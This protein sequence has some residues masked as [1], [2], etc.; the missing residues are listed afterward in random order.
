MMPETDEED[1]VPD[2]LTAARLNQLVAIG[3]RPSG[4][5][6]HLEQAIATGPPRFGIL[7][8]GRLPL[9]TTKLP[10]NWTESYVCREVK[11]PSCSRSTAVFG[12]SRKSDASAQGS[13]WE[14]Q[15]CAH[16]S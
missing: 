5:P 16:A 8:V 12:R 4:Q 11:E 2:E 13:K 15:Y 10:V 7:V 6:N 14:K 9:G 1:L 3:I